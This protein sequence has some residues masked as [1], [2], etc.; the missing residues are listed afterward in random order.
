MRLRR[1]LPASPAA[2]SRFRSSF[3]ALLTIV[4]VFGVSGCG[5]DETEAPELGPETESA[6]AAPPPAETRVAAPAA[7]N[8]GDQAALADP[9]S[10]FSADEIRQVTGRDDY[11]EGIS[12]DELG[13]GTGGGASCQW[14]AAPGSREKS[15]MIGIVVIPPREGERWTGRVRATPREDCTYQAAP[16]AGDGAFF[17]ECPNARSLPLYVPARAVDILVLSEVRPPATSDSVRP[18]LLDVA[19]AAAAKLR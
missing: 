7:L 13:E 17:E 16:A 10:L 19:K 5:G 15:P 9:C 1:E 4:L 18:M 12:G 11:M 3:F 6:E 2:A 8:D 14:S